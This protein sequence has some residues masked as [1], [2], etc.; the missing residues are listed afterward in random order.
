MREGRGDDVPAALGVDVQSVAGRLVVVQE[1]R[2]AV[3]TGP[4]PGNNEVIVGFISGQ[5]AVSV[6]APSPAEC[7]NPQHSLWTLQCPLTV[8][9]TA[10]HQS[11]EQNI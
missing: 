10:L 6:L 3:L 4:T 7:D 11:P 1:K 5:S 9:P 8:H 2:G